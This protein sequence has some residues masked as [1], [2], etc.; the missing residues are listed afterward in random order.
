MTDNK[1]FVFRFDDVEVRDREFILAKA[2]EVLPVE[3][4]AFRVLQ[5]LL[6]NPH[7]LVTK[8]E[9][10]DAV[11]S[12]VTVS[13]NSVARAVAQLR[14]LL[15]DDLREPRYIATVPT[16]G[17]RFVC[18]VEVLEDVS[19]NG[20]VKDSANVQ[21]ATKRWL[22]VL[23]AAVA[24]I[25]VTAGIAWFA[26][27]HATVAL[28]ELE[29]RRLTFNSGDNPVWALA[30]SPDGKYVAYGD[31]S[32]IHIKLIETGEMHTIPPP[33]V[34]S[35]D[36]TWAPMAWFPDGSKLLAGGFSWPSHLS[37]WTVSVLGGNIRM[38][39]DNAGAGNVSPVDS[40][41]AFAGPIGALGTRELW[42]MGA[43]G[44]EPHKFLS[45]DADSGLGSFVFSP[46]GKRLAYTRAHQTPDRIEMS[47][48]SRD[49]KGEHPV[50]TL[51]D[52]KLDETCCEQFC[53]MPDGR[54]IYTR[55]EPAPNESDNNFWEIHVDNTGKP[56]SKPRRVTN[57]SGSSQR[58]L[59]IS[60]DGKRLAF[61]K[62][63]GHG[64]IYVGELEANGTQLKTP[65]RLTLSEDYS[66]P[67]AWTFDS[68]AILFSSDRNGRLEIFKQT[69]NEE[70]AESLVTDPKNDL[71]NPFLSPDGSWLIYAAVP[72]L[73]SGIGASTPFNVMRLPISGGAPQIV[74][75]SRGYYGHQCGRSPASLCVVAEQSSDRRQLA[76]VGFDPVGGRERELTRID[77][78]PNA[79]YSWSVSLDGSS[80]AILKTGEQE[81]HVQI[82]FFNNGSVGSIRDIRVKGWNRLGLVYLMQDRRG[83]FVSSD[84]VQGSTLLH[85][86]LEGN[87]HV[88][89][90]QKGHTGTYGL[91]SPD[92]KTLALYDEEQ[93]INAWMIENF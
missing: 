48:E 78:D 45:V 70:Q 44:Q 40:Q 50:L 30:I 79:S 73:R 85:V 67:T 39:R 90:V 7:K 46:D 56:K 18:N 81:G 35:R 25:L 31:R 17:Y 47:I 15:G 27:R 93:D 33:A 75:T 53:W 63:T 3:P 74:L 60:V 41:I 89:W 36:A 64:S 88:L 13:E 28:S 42:T 86:D 69:L 5:Y 71:V 57:W 16:A 8:E 29:Q 83:L 76:F 52:P 87:A 59:R 6:R 58:N 38:L 51:S 61:L 49:L 4:K 68:G 37:T 80:L 11:W 55:R 77:T 62:Q 19:G 10:L 66:F 20:K 23:A 82:R 32:G 12:D 24:L 2:G 92:G 54:I 72:K 84:S 43:G 9:L 26:T 65:R 1:C 34:L 14:R 91:P 22:V 21:G